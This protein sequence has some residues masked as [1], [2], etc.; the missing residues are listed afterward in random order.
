MQ[1]RHLLRMCSA[2]SIISSVESEVSRITDKGHFNMSQETLGYPSTLNEY[3]DEA[4][5]WQKYNFLPENG[6][7]L[8]WSLQQLEGL[9]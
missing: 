3:K 7:G 2:K 9:H 1:L 5:A 8:V 4:F 6:H